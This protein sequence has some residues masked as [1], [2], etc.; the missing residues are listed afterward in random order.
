MHNLDAGRLLSAMN[1]AL[2]HLRNAKNLPTYLSNGT[3]PLFQVNEPHDKRLLFPL[4]E[5][6]LSFIE[7]KS[8]IERR[9]QI[10]TEEDAADTL[11]FCTR[12]D[13][14]KRVENI[15]LALKNQFKVESSE[16]HRQLAQ[17]LE[18][19][20]GVVD[21]L[22]VMFQ[23]SIYRRNNFEDAASCTGVTKA[24]LYHEG[25]ILLSRQLEHLRLELYHFRKEHAEKEAALIKKAS[26]D[27]KKQS[28]HLYLYDADL[29]S[30]DSLLVNEK[31]SYDA[32]ASELKKN[33]FYL[34][35]S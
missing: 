25:A 35:K 30:K 4:H 1:D 34:Q 29:A 13:S 22:E 11:A 2:V 23:D 15:L 26:N 6:V 31:L 18:V 16:R 28:E 8:S 7:I 14:E 17:G 19:K 33:V 32:A 5:L 9:L 12:V 27:E 20:T 24:A 10:T 21:E 3:Q